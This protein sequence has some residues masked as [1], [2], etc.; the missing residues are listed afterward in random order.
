MYFSTSILV[1]LGLSTATAVSPEDIF[2]RAKARKPVIEKRI[3]QEPFEN[4]RLERRASRF[5]T[6]KTEKFVVN[7]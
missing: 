5:R 1:F 6:E 7:G 3:P 2:T 4:E